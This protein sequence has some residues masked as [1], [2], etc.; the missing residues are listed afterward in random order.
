MEAVLGTDAAYLWIID[1]NERA[2]RFY[3]K[4]GFVDFGESVPAGQTW[5]GTPMHRMVR[6]ATAPTSAN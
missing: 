4:H 5:G 2:H 6:P 1:G 3:V